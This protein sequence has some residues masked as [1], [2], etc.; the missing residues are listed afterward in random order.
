MVLQNMLFFNINFYVFVY[1][2]ERFLLDFERPRPLQKIAKNRTNR[3]QIDIGAHLERIR[4]SMVALGGFWERF[5][6][7]LEWF[8]VGFGWIF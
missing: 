4:C 6:L 3:E 5:G 7:V 2:F 1:G 8:W